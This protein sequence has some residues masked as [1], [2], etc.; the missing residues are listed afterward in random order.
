M[1]IEKSIVKV[2]SVFEWEPLKLKVA[3]LIQIALPERSQGERAR[4][5]IATGNDLMKD[6]VVLYLLEG[7]KSR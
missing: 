5:L 3:E 1:T 7:R 4:N 2:I 6:A